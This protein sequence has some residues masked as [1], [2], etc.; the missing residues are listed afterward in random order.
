MKITSGEGLEKLEKSQGLCFC[1][2]FHGAF[3]RTRRA[4]VQP[5]KTRQ[6]RFS[7]VRKIDAHSNNYRDSTISE[8]EQLTRMIF[9]ILFFLRKKNKMKKFPTKITKKIGA[10]DAR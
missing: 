7:Y 4:C 3:L 9:G 2:R 8:T 5:W 6:E 10:H 1:L